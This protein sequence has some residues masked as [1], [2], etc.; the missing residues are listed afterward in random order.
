MD[1]EIDPHVLQE[2]VQI[3][4]VVAVV[5]YI[6]GVQLIEVFVTIGVTYVL[7]HFF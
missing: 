1:I 6:T 5:E 7:T 2:F 4:S 3:V